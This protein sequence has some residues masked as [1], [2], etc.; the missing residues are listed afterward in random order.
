MNRSLTGMIVTVSAMSS[1]SPV[2]AQGTYLPFNSNGTLV[3]PE[4]IQTQPKPELQPR[5]AAP[6]NNNSSTIPTTPSTTD[7]YK[8]PGDQTNSPYFGSTQT[9][10]SVSPT[11]VTP[12]VE[13]GAPVPAYAIPQPYTVNRWWN[14]PL[15][16]YQSNYQT[17]YGGGVMP[18]GGSPCNS[19]NPYPPPCGNMNF[20]FGR[21]YDGFMTGW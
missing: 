10:S 3:V 7:T 12:G 4:Q 6:Q 13:L 15:W 21:G 14:R 11:V 1:L 20:E 16:N 2:M 18:Y 8:A 9:P 17:N 19:C 5:P